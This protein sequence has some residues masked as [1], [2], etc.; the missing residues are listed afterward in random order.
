M[1]S[2]TLERLYVNPFSQCIKSVSLNFIQ[3]GGL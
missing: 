2:Y 3:E 1:I